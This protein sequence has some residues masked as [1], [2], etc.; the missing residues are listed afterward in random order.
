MEYP[1]LTP[2]KLLIYLTAIVLLPILLV[3]YHHKVTNDRIDMLNETLTE[4]HTQVV[5]AKQKNALN[6]QTRQHF[7]DANRFYLDKE[8]ES[9]PLL[10]DERMLLEKFV[11]NSNLAPNP[12]AS[13]R[14]KEIDSNFIVFSEGVIERY[15]TFDEFPESLSKPVEI[16][17]NDLKK[18]LSRIEG[19][20]IENQ[21]ALPKRPLLI[22]TDCRL[23]R[24]KV[25]DNTS[26]FL[27]NMK[28]L[29]REFTE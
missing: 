23:D 2:S 28:L 25:G 3:L 22:I 1:K 12:Q 17:N 16:D 9:I 20:T 6:A 19:V 11:K 21:T 15:P 7:Q 29:K 26:V 13:Q 14:L 4:L 24:K 18:I 10:K 8:V 5:I 27:L